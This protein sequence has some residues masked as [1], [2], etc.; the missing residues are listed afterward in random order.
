MHS[1]YDD[2][3][4]LY[5]ALVA[6]MAGKQ[7]CACR[8]LTILCLLYGCLFINGRKSELPTLPF[9]D[10]RDNNNYKCLNLQ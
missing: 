8:I 1:L 3:I 5:Y 9:T 7:V 4:S 6:R 2:G 10:S